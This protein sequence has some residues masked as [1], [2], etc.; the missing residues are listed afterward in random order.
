MESASGKPTIYDVAKRAGTSA[1]TVSRVV[2]GSTLV[3]SDTAQS[4]AAAM[5]D[6]G[7]VPRR[8][9]R[10]AARTVLNIVAFL[11]RAPEPHAHL[12]Y[13][14]AALVGGIYRG[15]GDTRAHLITA[16]AGEMTPFEG[17][18]LGDIDACLFAFGVPPARVRSLLAEREIPAVIINRRGDRLASV[19]SDEDRGMDLLAAH[20]LNARPHPRPAF[21][22]V[23]PAQGVAATRWRALRA[24]GFPVTDDDRREYAS[25]S[26]LTLNEVRR[27]LDSGYDTFVCVND[28]V[29]VALLERLALLGVRVPEDVSVTGY[30]NAPVRGLLSRDL[31]SVD[32]AVARQGEEAARLLTEA[33]LARRIPAGEVLVPAELIP[34]ETV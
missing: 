23:L 15:L 1:S 2:N 6:L 31:T 10:Q 13:D 20:I 25:V 32:L 28:L 8:I 3:S 21:L 5:A 11:P 34:G 18:K 24:T 22:T 29:A 14:V 26:G 9:R 30:D 4:V 12:F 27:M 17:K 16:L 33:V 7:F 19:A